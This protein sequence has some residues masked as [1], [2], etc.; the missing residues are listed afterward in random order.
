MNEFKIF[1]VTHLG[2]L[3]FEGLMILLLCI[4][5]KKIKENKKF[6]A[7]LRYAFAIFHIGFEISYYI[8]AANIGRPF[9]KTFPLELCGIGLYLS[10]IFLILDSEKLWQYSFP[11][12]I[13]G[14]ALA[15]LFG[16]PDGLDFPHFRFFQFFAGHGLLIITNLFG[17]L[18]LDYKM[19]FKE[20]KKTMIALY[21]TVAFTFVIDKITGANFMFLN[22]APFPI[23]FLQD[24]LGSFYIIPLFFVLSAVYYL[25]VYFLN[26]KTKKLVKVEN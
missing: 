1:G 11:I 6:T 18:V 4:M 12:T 8:W 13:I 9:L 15:C 3:V 20:F 26:L 7:F 25:P 5:H 2:F 19:G 24:Y 17:A 23:E 16:S 21:I 22:E 14:A 10:V